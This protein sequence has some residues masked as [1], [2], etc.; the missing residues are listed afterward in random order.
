MYGDLTVSSWVR[1]D[2][3]CPVRYDVL[4]SAEAQFVVGRAPVEFEFV[5][6]ADALREFL[7][8]GT[9]ALNTMDALFA[10]EEAERDPQG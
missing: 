10:Q 6:E 3:G 7:K 8:I 2:T 1:V 5:M 9:E 4:G